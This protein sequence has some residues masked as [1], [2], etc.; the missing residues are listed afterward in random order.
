MPFPNNITYELL[1]ENHLTEVT[2]LLAKTLHTRESLYSMLKIPLKEI[3]EMLEIGMKIALSEKL[4][5]VAIDTLTKKIVGCIIFCDWLTDLSSVFVFKNPEHVSI[6]AE[7]NTVI[8]DSINHWMKNNLKQEKKGQMAYGLMMAVDVDYTNKKVGEALVNRAMAHLH[9]KG[10]KYI[11]G[12]ITSSYAD[13]YALKRKQ[14]ELLT[15]E[16][17]N[18]V[19]HEEV[20]N[21]IG[22]SRVEKRPFVNVPGKLI[23]RVIEVSDVLT[24]KIGFYKNIP[25]EKQ[26]VINYLVLQTQHVPE[27]IELLIE[28]FSGQDSFYSAIQLSREELKTLF[29]KTIDIILPQELSLVAIDSKTNKVIACVIYSDVLT[30]FNSTYL[31]LEKRKQDLLI[32]WDNWVEA[33]LKNWAASEGVEIEKGKMVWG[34]VSAVNANYANQKIGTIIFLKA[35]HYLGATPYEYAIADLTSKYAVRQ[36]SAIIQ[37]EICAINYK[38]FVFGGT[39]PFAESSEKLILQVAPLPKSFEDKP[40]KS[41]GLQAKL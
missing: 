5:F 31:F 18:F 41:I 24:D 16:Y 12:D 17:N 23:V 7:L 13:K 15:I 36:S 21:N 10:F 40:A 6:L 35:F 34:L 38:D 14:T 25:S 20:S 33:H 37:R 2:D 8:A 3:Y 32:A 29:K 4:S 19:Y 27:V 9:A 39:K 1:T 28:A 11:C 30:D 22:S 26:N